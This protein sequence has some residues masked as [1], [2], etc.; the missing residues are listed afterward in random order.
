MREAIK[1]YAPTEIVNRVTK[2]HVGEYYNYSYEK[3]FEEMKEQILN[4]PAD[5]NEYL[6]LDR[7]K[8]F[9]LKDSS[10]LRKNSFQHICV[11][12]NWHEINNFDKS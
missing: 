5:I 1:E 10:T 8:N 4:A 12:V 11:L 9:N 7:I 2:S 3:N 6:D